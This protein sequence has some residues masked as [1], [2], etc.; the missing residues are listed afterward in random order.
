[1]AKTDVYTLY[2][3]G[4]FQISKVSPETHW[5]HHLRDT[6]NGLAYSLM[7]QPVFE[8]VQPQRFDT[9][10][11]FQVAGPPLPHTRPRKYMMITEAGR[12]FPKGLAHKICAPSSS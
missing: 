4:T 9:W 12:F 5:P 1:M 10:E 6:R 8:Q 7:Q 2:P 11:E 3:N